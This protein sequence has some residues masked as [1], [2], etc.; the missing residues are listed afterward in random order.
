MEFKENSKKMEEKVEY[1]YAFKCQQKETLLSLY[2][3][4]TDLEKKMS[5]SCG[6]LYKHVL[7][8]I[9]FIKTLLLSTSLQ[10][11]FFI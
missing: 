11:S 6:Q 5:I 10:M 7:H 8:V 4:I 1:S 9:F 2:K 3:I